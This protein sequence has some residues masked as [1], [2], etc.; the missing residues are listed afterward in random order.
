[1]DFL[2]LFPN[3]IHVVIEIDGKQHYS[4]HDGKASPKLYAEMVAA[5]REL[6]LDGYEIFRFG[7]NEFVNKD[8]ATKVIREFV[9]K[10]I[11]LHS[12]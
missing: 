1:M 9:S 3:R 11:A 12:A 4:D 7:G 6:K 5:D 10:L 2:I 8:S